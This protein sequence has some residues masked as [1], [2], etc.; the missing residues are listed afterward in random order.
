MSTTEITKVFKLATRISYVNDKAAQSDAGGLQQRTSHG[1]C[2][3]AE[4]N[5][6]HAGV[7]RQAI[8]VFADA[9]HAPVAVHIP[10]KGALNAGFGK[11]PKKDLARLRSRRTECIAMSRVRLRRR[12]RGHPPIIEVWRSCSAA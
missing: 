4:R 10:V 1:V 8:Q 5:H 7:V 12:R 6:Q 2:R 9:K 3:F 11:R